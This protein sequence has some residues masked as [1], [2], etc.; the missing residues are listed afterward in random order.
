VDVIAHELSHS[1]SGNLVTNATWEHMFLNEG[2]TMYLERRI[3][4]KV[5]GGSEHF[6]FSAIIGWNALGK[7]KLS[8]KTCE[9]LTPSCR[10]VHRKIRRR[11]SLH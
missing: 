4:E 7:Y 3:I 2:W 1:W 5:H 10:G 8:F 6:H 11:S 9:V